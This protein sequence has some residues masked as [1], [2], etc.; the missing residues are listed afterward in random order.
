MHAY[1][2]TCIHLINIHGNEMGPIL[3]LFTGRTDDSDFDIFCRKSKYPHLHDVCNL[4]FQLQKLQV[5]IPETQMQGFD[6]WS[7]RSVQT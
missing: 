3:F 4:F 7:Q 2:R 6:V 5:S 1:V